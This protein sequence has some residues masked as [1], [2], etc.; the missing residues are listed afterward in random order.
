MISISQMPRHE[1]NDYLQ[2]NGIE[3]IQSTKRHTDK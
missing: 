3:H 2:L 1:T